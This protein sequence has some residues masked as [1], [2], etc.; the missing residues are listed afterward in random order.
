M[1]S[2]DPGY[3]GYRPIIEPLTLTTGASFVQTIQ[4][5]SG[6]VF[7]AGTAIG[8]VLT[9]PSGNALGT[10]WATVTATS[11]MWT[12]PSITADSIPVNTRYTMLATFPTTPSTTYAWYEGAIVRT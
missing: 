6:G 1:T 3:L 7:P 2:S 11:A 9:D 8:I 4:P 5:S 10:W 12:V